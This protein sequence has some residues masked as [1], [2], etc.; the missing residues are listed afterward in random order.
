MELSIYQK[1]KNYIKKYYDKHKKEKVICE[2]CK[3]EILKINKTR[4]EKSIYHIERLN[5]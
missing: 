4:H 5:I 1:N 2:I 3:R